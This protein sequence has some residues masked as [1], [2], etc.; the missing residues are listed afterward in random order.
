MA[1]TSYNVT[2][3][4]AADA[5]LVLTPMFRGLTGT[6][7]TVTVNHSTNTTGSVWYGF[8]VS[9]PAQ[10]SGWVIFRDASN[11]E[12]YLIAVNPREL[13]NADTPTS[14]FAALVGQGSISVDHNYGGTDALS[15][16]DANGN[17]VT[18]AIVRAYLTSDYNAGNRD[19]TYI[20]AET[21]TTVAG[22]WNW[23]MLLNAGNYT[24]VYFKAGYYLPATT[25]ITVS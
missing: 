12:I 6:E 22:R 17:G 13:E 19:L 9:V 23:P 21:T 4:F 2:I 3:S 5:G 11:N 24:L 18:D 1:E 20:Q 25:T 15:Y 16:Q 7:S 14:Q 8:D 10:T